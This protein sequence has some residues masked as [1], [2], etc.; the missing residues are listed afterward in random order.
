[1]QEIRTSE[2]TSLRRESREGEGGIHARTEDYLFKKWVMRRCGVVESA[3][4][5]RN[6]ILWDYLCKKWV[7]GSWGKGGQ[8]MQEKVKSPGISII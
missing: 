3:I 6:N 8:S 2:N 5:A 7:M 1:M 4:H